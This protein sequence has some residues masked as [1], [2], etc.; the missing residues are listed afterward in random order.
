M[1]KVWIEQKAG[2]FQLYTAFGRRSATNPV[3]SMEA[4]FTDVS[5]A[6]RELN[7]IVNKKKSSKGYT[8]AVSG[9]PYSD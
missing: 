2:K 6:E 3:T 4:E 7:K 1:Y 8:T 9:I 5:F